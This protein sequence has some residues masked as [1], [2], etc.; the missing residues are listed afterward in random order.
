VRIRPPA[1]HF[2]IISPAIVNPIVMNQYQLTLHPFLQA[3]QTRT[4]MNRR[5]VM[6]TLGNPILFLRKTVQGGVVN[7]TSTVSGAVTRLA[8]VV[9]VPSITSASG[10]TASLVA[11]RAVQGSTINSTSTV[12]TVTITGGTQAGGGGPGNDFPWAVPT[13]H[14]GR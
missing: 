9:P 10:L 13:Y 6:Y 4:T 3:V 14:H 2:A 7:S 12:L 11:L 1:V 8:L 5:S